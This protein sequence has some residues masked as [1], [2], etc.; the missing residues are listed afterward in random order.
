MPGRDNRGATRHFANP[1]WF[2]RFRG[3]QSARSVGA[4][5]YLIVGL[6]RDT[7]TPWHDN[8]RARDAAAAKE[9]ARSRAG[10]AGVDLVVAAA[11]GPDVRVS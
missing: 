4:V 8:V 5:I 3:R 6:D 7:M 9:I 2:P 10:A 11:I 1:W